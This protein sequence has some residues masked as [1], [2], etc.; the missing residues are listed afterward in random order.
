MNSL[1]I[2]GTVCLIL[3]ILISAAGSFLW[4]KKGRRDGR[5]DKI[6]KSEARW[7]DY[8]M[9]ARAEGCPC[10]RPAT[11]VRMSGGNVGSVPVEVW[12]CDEHFNVS[13]WSRDGGEGHWRA[14]GY[15]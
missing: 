14:V 15:D 10:G 9:K 3:G 7:I 6:R 4:S 11:C 8:N 13:E 5:T 2:V 1:E 12:S